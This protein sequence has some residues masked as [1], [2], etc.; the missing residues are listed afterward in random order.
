[1]R[2]RIRMMLLLTAVFLVC[3]CV[4]VRAAQAAEQNV[5]DDAGLLTQSERQDLEEQIASFTE[6]SGWNVFAVTTSDT[7]GKSTMAY[8]DDFFDEHSPEQEDGVAVVIDMDNRQIYISTC[9]IAIRYLTDERI[10]RILDD[11]Y[12]DISN[13]EYKAC[14]SAMLDGVEEYYREGIPGNQYNYD[15][16]TGKISRYRHITIVEAL[17][18][19]LLAVACGAVV[20]VSVVRKYRLK[21]P[22][23]HYDFRENGLL[24][25]RERDDRFINQTIT[26]RKIPQQTSGGGGHS[27][28][29]RSSTHTSSSGRSHGGGGRSF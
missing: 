16:E 10:D 18:A 28:A 21:A 6:V 3:G 4:G 23:F 20:W 9:G 26:H 17:I 2:K 25:L 5:Y 22:T 14:L 7:G 27:S 11:A 13:G 29:G 8:A 12:T 15:T 24:H 1:M 19:V